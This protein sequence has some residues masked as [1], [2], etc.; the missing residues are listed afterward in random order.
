MRGSIGGRAHAIDPHDTRR[1][2]TLSAEC[3]PIGR[4]DQRRNL[5]LLRSL[6]PERSAAAVRQRERE[7]M[8]RCSVGR[9]SSGASA[10]TFK[11]ISSLGATFTR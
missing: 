1:T 2:R 8:I 5:A 4:N 6:R 10:N 7:S 3:S 9:S 11:A